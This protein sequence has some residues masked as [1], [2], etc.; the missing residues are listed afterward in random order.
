VKTAGEIDVVWIKPVELSDSVEL[1][2][3]NVVLNGTEF[4][5]KSSIFA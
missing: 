1:N 2:S 5:E 3:E 4:F